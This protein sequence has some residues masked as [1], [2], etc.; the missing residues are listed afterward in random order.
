[1]AGLGA[2]AS[3]SAITGATKTKITYD[4]KGLVTAGADATTADIASSA[5]KRYVTDAQLTVIG[6]TSGTNTGDETTAGIRTKLG[7]TTL[8]GSNTGDET[9]AGIRTKLGITTLSGSNTGDQTIT[10]T[11]DVTGNLVGNV[12]G[13][14][15]G[16]ASTTTQLATARRI[17]GNSFDDIKNIKKNIIEMNKDKNNKQKKA[18]KDKL[19]KDSN[20]QIEN[21]VKLSKNGK[22]IIFNEIINKINELEHISNKNNLEIANIV[23]KKLFVIKSS[24]NSKKS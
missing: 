8:S 24:I 9:A 11:G 2:V 14:L 20:D 1:V 19:K 3:N 5:D 10:L 16:N 23:F 12:T 7:I 18:A 22:D 4:S 21:K 17:Y 6:N 13:N 15:A